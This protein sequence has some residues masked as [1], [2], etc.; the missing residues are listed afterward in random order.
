MLVKTRTSDTSRT[1]Q[2]CSCI[3]YP[4]LFPRISWPN[5]VQTVWPQWLYQPW[6]QIWI[7]PSSLTG[8]CVR[9]E[10]C[11]TIWTGPQAEEGVSLSLL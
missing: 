9:S 5:R 8:P 3:H 2:M 4:A 11:T 1:G 10:H 7:G 6:P